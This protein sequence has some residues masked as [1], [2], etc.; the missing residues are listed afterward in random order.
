MSSSLATTS[1]T[2][3]QAGLI[4]SDSTRQSGVGTPDTQCY[5]YDQLGRLTQAFTTTDQ[6]NDPTTGQIQGI[7]SCADTNPVAG[8]V[9]GGPAPYWQ[10][11]GY[12]ALGDRVQQTNHD[13]S[14]TSTANNTTQTLAYTGYNAATSAHHR[15]GDPRRGPVR[16][17]DGAEGQHHQ[18]LRLRWPAPE[19]SSH[20]L[21]RS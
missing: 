5:S 1:Y 8:K 20:P 17:H 7:G 11:Y 14:V 3:D 2:Y 21:E 10:T 18:Q 15:V 19:S 16:D 12:D 4:T 9:T 13:T 6:V